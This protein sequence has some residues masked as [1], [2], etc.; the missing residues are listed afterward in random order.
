MLWGSGDPTREF[1]YV[2]DAAEAI[3]LAAERYDGSEPVNI[4]AGRE[5]RIRDLARLIA[6]MTGFTGDI[7]WD[8]SKPDG[9]PR[10]ALN[11]SRAERYFGFRAGMS[12][13]DGLRQTID[14]YRMRDIDPKAVLTGK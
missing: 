10:R 12:L 1:L 2:E 7:V 6:D 14:W 11:T 4:G 13:E 8:S 9:Q 5:I 3:L